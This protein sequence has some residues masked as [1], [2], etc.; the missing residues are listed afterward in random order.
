MP[1]A[2]HRS[3]ACSLL[4]A[5]ALDGARPV[6]P[7][8]RARQ[9]TPRASPRPR[10]RRP[11]PSCRRARV[12][13]K[14]ACTTGPSRASREAYRLVPSPKVLYN[15][16]IAYLSVARYADA[17]AALEQF[18]AEATDAPAANQDTARRHIADLRAKVVTLELKSDRPGAELGL[19]GRG[20]GARRVRPPARHRRRA[21]RAARARRGRR[22]RSGVHGPAR[23]VDDAVTLTFAA[24]NGAAGATTAAGAGDAR[25]R[26]ARPEPPALAP[27]RRRRRARARSTGGPGSG[28]RSAAA[29][30]SRRRSSS[31]SRSAAPS[32]RRSTRKWTGLDG[33]RQKPRTRG[34]SRGRGAARRLRDEGGVSPRQRAL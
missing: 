18:L 20:L 28:R 27:A 29:P 31:C 4:D 5:A 11:R 8:W 34:R 16:G 7:C 30:P 3:R 32:I 10:A 2:S 13:W 12:R 19:D 17:L 25:A 23:S 24:A 21:A 15:L 22:R 33:A 14:I 26:A 9:P 6:G 1:K